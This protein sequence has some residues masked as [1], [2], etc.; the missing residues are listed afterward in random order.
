M[1]LPDRVHLPT[2][3]PLVVDGNPETQLTDTVCHLVS[4]TGKGLGCPAV[5]TR[6]DLAA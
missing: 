5:V 3:L 2:Y 6:R 1:P 4:G